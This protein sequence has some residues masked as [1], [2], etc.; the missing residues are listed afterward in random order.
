MKNLHLA[1]LTEKKLH[2][3]ELFLI[4]FEMWRK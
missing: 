2:R 3:E 1:V 4:T